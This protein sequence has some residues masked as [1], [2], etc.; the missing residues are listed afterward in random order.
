MI[1]TDSGIA[2]AA[3]IA[4]AVSD[5][6]ALNIMGIDVRGRTSYTDFLV[7]C[8]GTSDRHV[9]AVAESA[10]SSLRE[11][12][13]TVTGAEGLRSG[14]WALVDFGS[15]VLHVF[16]QFSREV[17]NLEDLWKDAPRLDFHL[18]SDVSPLSSASAT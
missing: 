6:K 2:L 14:Q 13:V 10:M 17:Y 5:K 4:E 16:H 7:L 12:G 11:E 18:E 15:V 9:Q 1:D 3:R 8:S